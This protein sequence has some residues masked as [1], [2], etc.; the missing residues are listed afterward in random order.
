MKKELVSAVKDFSK[1]ELEEQL[2]SAK[3]NNNQRD[4]KILQAELKRRKK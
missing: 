1:K 4:I 3:R 2:V